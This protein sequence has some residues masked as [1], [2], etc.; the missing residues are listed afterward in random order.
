MVKIWV[1]LWVYEETAEAKISEEK[2]WWG[3]WRVIAACRSF[4]L[5]A[6][7]F[8]TRAFWWLIEAASDVV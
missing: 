1:D 8:G 6:T 2:R 7:A 3:N 4:G 5:R